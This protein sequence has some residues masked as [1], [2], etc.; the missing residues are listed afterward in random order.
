MNGTYMHSIKTEWS[1]YNNQESLA[2][3]AI[4][5]RN[6]TTT[7]TQ[8]VDGRLNDENVHLN[9][10]LVKKVFEFSMRFSAIASQF[11][12]ARRR[13]KS[14][15]PKRIEADILILGIDFSFYIHF[16]SHRMFFVFL[17]RC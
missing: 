5:E 17:N 2:M 6:E 13:K 3:A 15:S 1:F 7:T 16:F 14:I 12:I 4:T 9:Y 10:S 8:K 11:S